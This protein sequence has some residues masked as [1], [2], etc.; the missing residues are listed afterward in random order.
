MEDAKM[1]KLYIFDTSKK[2][3]NLMYPYRDQIFIY[4]KK[5]NILDLIANI[6]KAANTDEE[7]VELGFA[8]EMRQR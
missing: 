5:E 1:T 6:A 2:T 4:I 7:F 3:S 8:G